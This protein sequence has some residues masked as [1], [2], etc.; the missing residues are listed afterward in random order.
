MPTDSEDKEDA[1]P[2]EHNKRTLPMFPQLPN[3]VIL[4]GKD[5]ND[6]LTISFIGY[7]IS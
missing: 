3:Q 6:I 2:M 5:V 4:S 1:E 7:L